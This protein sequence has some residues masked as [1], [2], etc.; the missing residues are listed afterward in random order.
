MFYCND[1]AEKYEYPTS[2]GKSVGKCEVCD[3]EAACNDVPSSQLPP[4]KQ[5]KITKEDLNWCDEPII[6]MALIIKGGK[7]D[8]KGQPLNGTTFYEVGKH[9]ESGMVAIIPTGK[10]AKEDFCNDVLNAKL[11]EGNRLN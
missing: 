4:P 2:I 5:Q 11:K 3:K 10:D 1:C 9:K 7:I 6:G 8:S